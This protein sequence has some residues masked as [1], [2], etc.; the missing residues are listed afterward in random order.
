MIKTDASKTIRALDKLVDGL[1]RHVPGGVDRFVE[2]EMKESQRLVPVDT[3]ELK[4]S[5][6]QD[7]C[8]KRRNDWVASFGYTAEYAAIVHEDLSGY[9]PNGQAKYLEQPFNESAP[10]MPQRV[11]EYVAGKVGLK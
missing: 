10:Y 7:S 9:H 2:I 4:A 3:G 5:D 8:T 6:Y 1:E 11:I